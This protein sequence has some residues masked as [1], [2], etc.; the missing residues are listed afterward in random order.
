MQRVFFLNRY[1]YPDHSASSQLLT[2]L[3]F[4]LTTAGRQLYVITSQQ[5]YDDPASRL[6][7]AETIKGIQV[8]RVPTTQFGRN[9]LLGRGFDYFSFY[10]SAWRALRKLLRSGDIVVAMTDPPLV[11]IVAMHAAKRHGARLVNWLQ[12]VYPEVAVEL[13]VPVIRGPVKNA[14]ARLRD[15]TLQKAAATVVVGQRMRDKITS[16]GASIDNIKVIHNWSD[17]HQISPVNTADNPLRN[18]WG[19]EN[20]FVVGYSGNLGRAHE[21]D[22]VLAASERLRHDS[23]IM[24][25]FI[26]GGHRM[27]ELERI[28]KRRG[29]EAS[30][31]F[32]PYQNRQQLKHSLS[33]PD[34]HWISLKPEVEGMIVPS[35]FY[36]IAAAGRPTIAITASDGEIA[37]LILEHNCGVVIEPGQGDALAAAITR[38][39]N[40]RHSLAAMGARARAMLD[41]KFTRRQALDQWSAV[42]DQVA[43]G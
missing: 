26:G 14:F 2:D 6:P 42:L 10:A 21:F 39:S 28:V 17:D 34:I 27:G 29:L 30:F 38:L 18:A 16:L 9:V 19:L 24:F 8:I 31:R 35:K 37:Q 20:K 22:T 25:V 13:G 12:D 32:L 11:S 36:G 23:R 33:V 43:R 1:F 15:K 7:A 5:L 3:A 41:S 4:H 40:D